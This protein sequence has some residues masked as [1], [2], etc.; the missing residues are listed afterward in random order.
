MCGKILFCDTHNKLVMKDDGFFKT[1]FPL[2]ALCEH[3]EHIL[4]IMGILK[5]AFFLFNVRWHLC[6]SHLM[7]SID[8]FIQNAYVYSYY[9]PRFDSFLTYLTFSTLDNQEL[10]KL[11]Y[12]LKPFFLSIL[13]VVCKVTS[14]HYLQA[15]GGSGN[16]RR[17]WHAALDED[18]W[19]SCDG[20][21]VFWWRTAISLSVWLVF[22]LSH[23][24]S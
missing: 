8:I 20:G 16:R 3:I 13:K 1:L 21:T 4:L 14:T 24:S 6:W 2:I 17:L 5:S 10:S 11:M 7:P 12:R 22:L 18:N 23:T 19:G 15:F 9:Y